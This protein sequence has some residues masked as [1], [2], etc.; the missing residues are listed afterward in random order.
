MT[1]IQPNFNNI[2]QNTRGIY[3]LKKKSEELSLELFM[4][5]HQM[6][7]WG[8]DRLYLH[9]GDNI[10]GPPDDIDDLETWKEE[11]LLEF[12]GDN[13]NV[14]K[15]DMKS[16][17]WKFKI[18]VNGIERNFPFNKTLGQIGRNQK[19]VGDKNQDLDELGWNY[20]L[21]KNPNDIKFEVSKK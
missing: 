15:V 2:K 17:I 5:N 3:K 14:L 6:Y 11:Q 1:E 20:V 4:K 19:V 10:F 13:L 18:K 12:T 21:N 16:P 7:Q 9:T 8:I